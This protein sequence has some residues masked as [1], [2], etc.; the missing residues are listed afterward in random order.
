MRSYSL[1]GTCFD[2]LNIMCSKK[3]EMPVMPGASLREPTRYH[4]QKVMV[5]TLWSSW[6][7]TIRPFGSVWRS[8][9]K[10][11]GVTA[12]A[13]APAASSSAAPAA[14]GIARTRAATHAAPSAALTS[15]ERA[16]G[17]VELILGLRR[18]L[19]RA[20]APGRDVRA[21]VVLAPHRCPR[22]AAQH[23]ELP[24][25][26]EGVGDRALEERVA[27]VWR[28]NARQSVTGSVM[29]GEGAEVVLRAGGRPSRAA[30]YHA[31]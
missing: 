7:R 11:S 27:R 12:S 4:C 8:I 23:R 19:V 16:R 6:V 26:G 25:V 3:C 31:P 14:G 30:G 2:P 13:R 17:L 22:E 1:G 21:E 15:L 18:H 29:A 20:D 9:L 28:R 24:G 5:G 10:R